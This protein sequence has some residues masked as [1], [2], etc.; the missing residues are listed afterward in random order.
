MLARYYL[1]LRHDEVAKT[2]LNFH[3]KKLCPDKQITLSSNPEYIYKVPLQEQWWNILKKT[4]TKIQHN[5]PDWVIWNKETK[6]CSVI[7]FSCPLDTNIGRK[8]NKKLETHGPLIQNIQILYPN[9]KYE[10]API[11]IGTMGYAPKSLFN[12]LKMIR[13]DERE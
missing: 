2:V 3:L 11:I 8:V 10:V 7:E 1:P 4:A 13:F 6:L 9:Y 5:K 12:Y